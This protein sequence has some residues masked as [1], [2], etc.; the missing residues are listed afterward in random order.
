MQYLIAVFLLQLVVGNPLLNTP[1]KL[2]P[3]YINVPLVTFDGEDSTTF[4]FHELNDPVMVSN[5]ILGDGN[6]SHLLKQLL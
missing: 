2:S 4:K 6:L 3:P 1:Q 5:L